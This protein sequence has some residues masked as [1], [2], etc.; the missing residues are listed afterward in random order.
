[1]II[2]VD[3]GSCDLY[4]NRPMCSKRLKTIRVYYDAPGQL[5]FKGGERFKFS[6]SEAGKSS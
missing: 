4:L 3:R 6:A 2:L 1:M 5:R